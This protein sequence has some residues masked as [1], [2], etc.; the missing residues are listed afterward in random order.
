MGTT[1]SF[2][3]PLGRYHATPW[4]GSANTSDVEWPPSPWRI[5]RALIATWYA[6]WPDL[7][8]E[9]IDRILSRLGTPDA[10]LTPPAL[11]GSTRHYMPDP[12]HK[13]SETGNTDQV[14]DAFLA[15]VP[16]ESLLVHWAGDLEASD[17]ETLRK[18]VELIPYLGRSES[19]CVA[20]LWDD[21]PTIDDG[22][23]RLGE[24]GEGVRQVELLA[25]DGP[26][27]RE[28]LEATTTATRKGRRLIPLGAHA[29]RYGTRA[30]QRSAPRSFARPS[31]D[32]NCVRLDLSSP[33]PVREGN[34]ILATDALHKAIRRAIDGYRADLVGAFI[35]VESDGSPRQGPHDHLH[36]L[37]LPRVRQ[38]RP[39][40]PADSVTA[41]IFLWCPGGI[42]AEF[43]GTIQLDVHTIWTQERRNSDMP[44]Q[45]LLNAGAGAVDALLP[46]L[47]GPAREWVS[48]TPYLPVR[49][50]KPNRPAA[51]FLAEELATECG[52]RALP[53]P[54]GLAVV[55]SPQHRR[56]IV[57]YRRRRTV[58]EMR[59]RR[60]GVYLR[61]RF[62]EAVP[63]PLALG[64][65]SHFGYG[66]F[67]PTDMSP[68][69]DLSGSQEATG[70]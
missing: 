38:I 67:M 15:V 37:P 32:I 36:L 5:L 45:Y 39:F 9:T 1:L 56:E 28:Y 13:R 69:G 35:G 66:L 29:A 25:P 34:A 43:A 55:D 65:L 12:K 46:N 60:P 33:V 70:G 63:G 18:L 61:M 50:R 10:Y 20:T 16:E 24:D 42:P 23:W 26:P 7:P 57:R 52:Y 17:R 22:W 54:T 40:L 2:T 44:P 6:R 58:E 27:P 11:P 47:T 48:V 64:Q 62:A 3:F 31:L 21:E 30:P 14:I 59:R 8:S 19:I 49:H 53:S 68:A 51:A 41:S 4:E